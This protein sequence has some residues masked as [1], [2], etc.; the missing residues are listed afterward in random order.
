M[1]G[2]AVVFLIVSALA[3]S[4]EAWPGSVYDA[5][6]EPGPLC[7]FVPPYES[8]GL[9]CM[10]AQSCCQ[11]LGLNSACRQDTVPLTEK[12]N[13]IWNRFPVLRHEVAHD[14]CG[15]SSACTERFEK[16]ALWLDDS[17]LGRFRGPGDAYYT[18][19][20]NVIR[21]KDLF[22]QSFRTKAD[23]DHILLHELGHS[24]QSARELIPVRMPDGAIVT[25]GGYYAR[26]GRS[27][28]I[29]GYL[30]P[31]MEQALGK[32]AAS[33][34]LDSIDQHLPNAK[35]HPENDTTWYNEA[36]ADLIFAGHLK[37]V[38]SVGYDCAAQEDTI[39]AQP[40][41]YLGCMSRFPRR[42]PA[43]KDV[44]AYA[45]SLQTSAL[46]S[47]QTW[48]CHRDLE[49]NGFLAQACAKVS[50]EWDAAK[51]AKEL[52]ELLLSTGAIAACRP[53]FAV[54]IWNA[55]GLSDC[56][57][58]EEDYKALGQRQDDEAKK[59]RDDLVLRAGRVVMRSFRLTQCGDSD[60][61]KK[62]RDRV[63]EECMKPGV[64]G[65]PTLNTQDAR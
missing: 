45:L 61:A 20:T 12:R 28:P 27:A 31:F 64:R 34:M 23:A 33:C 43:V 40:Q 14:C 13:Y 57:A 62:F 49:L 1:R 4:R 5:F 51:E 41:T 48:D 36:F 65:L 29:R 53:R 47:I 3:A 39:H 21:A 56:A 22:M 16:T 35:V 37:S 59:K 19:D 17:Y 24:C 25:A 18:R 50:A 42:P 63:N 6:L 10:Q 60:A 30:Q 46:A 2:A 11:S 7:L 9:L 52:G 55:S 15:D 8:V 54:P 32:S 44:Y 58:L 26:Y 38:G